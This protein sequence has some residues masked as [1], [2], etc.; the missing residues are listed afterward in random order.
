V[1]THTLLFFSAVVMAFATLL[2]AWWRPEQDRPLTLVF[3]L[4]RLGAWGRTAACWQ[5]PAL[6]FLST[7]MVWFSILYGDCDSADEACEQAF[8]VD[9]LPAAC[10][11]VLSGLL[12][13]AGTWDV[14]RYVS[15]RLVPVFR[16]RRLPPQMVAAGYRLPTVPTDPAG[17]L[18]VVGEIH[19]D[20]VYYANGDYRTMP[21][22][23]ARYSP[24]PE[25]LVLNQIALATGLLIYGSTGSGKTAF[26]I[27]SAAFD[28]FNHVTRPGGLV[29]DSKASLV[30]PLREAMH[31][32]GRDSDLFAIG[33]YT[34]VRWNPIHIPVA[35]AAR[36]AE[37]LLAAKENVNGARFNAE[38]RWI[39][40]GAAHL[41]EGA[42]GILRMTMPDSYVTAAHLRRLLS[43]LTTACQGEDKPSEVVSAHILALFDNKEPVGAD[44][45][46]YEHFRDLL[47]SRF[48]ED[49]K[50]RAIY[51]NELLG[52]LVR[53]TDPAVSDRFNAPL[54]DLDMPSFE[55]ATERGLVCVLDCNAKDQPGLSVL[56]G[57]LLKLGY[58]DCM[59]A[60]PV[61]TD[62]GVI[63]SDRCMVLCIDEYQQFA[64]LSDC[65]YVAVCR[66]SKSLTILATQGPASIKERLGED[67]THVLTQSLRNK[68]I[69]NCE[70][71][72]KIAEILGQEDVLDINRT[73]N[74]S[75]QDAS[76]TLSGRMAGQSSVSETLSE[77]HRRE[78]TVKPEDIRALALGECLFRGHDGESAIPVQRVF[79]R[80][81]FAADTRH[82][83]GDFALRIMGGAYV[84][85]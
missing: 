39:R 20:R 35:S 62:R 42:I 9:L 4:H 8:T 46:W 37:M 29:M 17:P 1:I 55:E 74:E 61:L 22:R 78:F 41:A 70:D 10:L 50:F 63:T 80:P 49:E 34:A 6:V 15:A 82:A 5:V 52:L 85:A 25:W 7:F 26:L 54:A 23:A 73:V 28:L 27:L 13:T 30:K 19:P 53:L 81:C 66:Q 77:Q 83:D 65:E 36:I 56:L 75:Q 31:K 3:V 32:F 51:T 47:I 59:I 43:K 2:L 12:V 24:A 33:P 40:D 45:V 79:P 84:H 69:F 16:G 21:V 72:D 57:T 44:A 64:S 58:E 68:L 38:Q 76:M 67:Q 60:R 14:L 48:S 71:A 18:L 11:A